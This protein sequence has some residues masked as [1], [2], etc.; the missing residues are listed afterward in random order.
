MMYAHREA[1]KDLPVV[2]VHSSGRYTLR[3]MSAFNLQFDNE[4][5]DNGL[6]TSPRRFAEQGV[7]DCTLKGKLLTKDCL[8][9]SLRT[10]KL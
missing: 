8:K 10:K 9:T 5:S 1:H 7:V 4:L 3:Q 2:G 6:E